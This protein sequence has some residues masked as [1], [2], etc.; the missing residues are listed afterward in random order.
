MLPSGEP[1][2]TAGNLITAA[3]MLA[4]RLR[5]N[6]AR[7]VLGAPPRAWTDPDLSGASVKAV[8][9]QEILMGAQ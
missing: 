9:W 4:L 7:Q 1:P 5:I 2:A 6:E 8:H 3:Q